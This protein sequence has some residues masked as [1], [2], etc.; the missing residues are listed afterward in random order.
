MAW[1][2]KNMTFL[3]ELWFHLFPSSLISVTSCCSLN[4]P[5]CS[6]SGACLWFPLEWSSPPPPTSPC[7]R[8]VLFP[9]LLEVL[10]QISSWEASSGHPNLNV[11]SFS[12]TFFPLPCCGL[13]S[14]NIHFYLMYQILFCCVSLLSLHLVCKFYEDREFCQFLLCYIPARKTIPDR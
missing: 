2:A 14:L 4:M 9:N 7:F 3:R 5:T 12:G 11:Q 6:S 1:K 8:M 13:F 10:A